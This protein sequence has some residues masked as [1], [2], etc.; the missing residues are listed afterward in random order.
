MGRHDQVFEVF[1]SGRAFNSAAGPLPQGLC[2][3]TPSQL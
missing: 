2:Q 1:A 3:G